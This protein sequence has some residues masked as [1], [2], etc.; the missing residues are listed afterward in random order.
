VL[1]LFVLFVET[2]VVAFILLEGLVVAPEGFDDEVLLV[3]FHA[4][5]GGDIVGLVGAGGGVL[6]AAVAL[7]S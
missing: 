2:V 7:H 5:G 6:L 3:G 4:V 1:E